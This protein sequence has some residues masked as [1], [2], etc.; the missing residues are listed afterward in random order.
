VSA[1]RHKVVIVEGLIGSGKTTLSRELGAALGQKTLILFEPDEKAADGQSVGNPYLADY[2]ADPNRWSFVLQVHQ[3]QAR[4]RMHLQAQW[5]A[6]QGTGHA[7][8]DRS[9]FGD[10]AFARL[11][12]KGGMMTQREFDT[13]SSIYHAMTAHVMLPSVCVRVLASPEI[14][15]RR[16]AGR[17]E[18]ET[19]RKCEKA[20]DLDYLRGLEQEI[21]HMVS[22]LRGM[23]VNVIDMAWDDARPDPESRHQ[24]VSSLAA[25]I[26]SLESP[27]PFLDMHR[28]TIL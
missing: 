5:H 15:E 2:Y 24:A 14:C 10:T 25:R 20:I 21:D 9:Y 7:V 22:V 8:L 17:M 28:R 13:Y 1:Q 23:S 18:K 12:L 16:V 4:Y 19:G 11:Q 6:M 26:M 3:L 27:D